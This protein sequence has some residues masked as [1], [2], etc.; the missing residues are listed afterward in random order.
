MWTSGSHLS[1]AWLEVQLLY[2]CGMTAAHDNWYATWFNSPFYHILYQHRNHEEAAQFIDNLID[3][4]QPTQGA[5]MLDLA[6]GRGRHSLYL[7]RKGFAVTGVDLSP[8]NIKQAN[9]IQCGQLDFAVHDMRD[10]FRPGFFE[11]VFNF[12]TSFGYFTREE[13]NYQTIA[14]IAQ[15]LKPGGTVVIDFLNAQQVIDNL[16][17]Q[18]TKTI[19]GITFDIQKHYRPPF[20][21]KEIRFQAEG[22]DYFFVER[23]QAL[24]KSDFAKY[25]TQAGLLLKHTFGSYSLEPFIEAT[26]ERL[27][28]IAQKPAI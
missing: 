5:T 24:C 6:C 25:F 28:L 8:V 15:N 4:L 3:F 7:C 21:E 16:V 27:I 19:S 11:Y 10:P 22:S 2:F 1:L 23:V 18:E 20:I 14:A 9:T 26:A 13:D 12:F 17:T